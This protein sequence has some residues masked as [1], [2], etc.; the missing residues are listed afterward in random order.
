MI[1]LQVINRILT[2]K[3]LGYFIQ[4]GVT[5]DYFKAYK[6]EFNFILDHYKKYGNIPDKET[7]GNKFQ[8]FNFLDVTESEE[9]LIDNLLET[10]L[11]GEMVPFVHG[12]AEKLKNDSTA[13]IQFARTE[14]ERL[15]KIGFFREGYDIINKAPERL[16][17]YERRKEAKG[18]LGITTGLDDLDE[19]T[20]GWLQED[21]ISIVGRTNEGKTW[22][23]LFFLVAAWK[24]G[25]KILLYSG[26]MGK[27]MI[28][29]RIDTILGNFSNLGLIAGDEILGEENPYLDIPKR[30]S[31][32]YVKFVDGLNVEDNPFI[33]ITPSD[34]GGKKLDVV[35]LHSL[36]EKYNPDIVGIDQISLMEDIRK[37]ENKRIKYANISE[38]LYLTSERYK[39]PVLVPVQAN[40]EIM[41]EKKKDITPGIEHIGEADA[42]G[43][44][45]TRIISIRQVDGTLKIELRKNRYGLNNQE[46][47]CIWDIDR[48]ILKPA[49]KISAEI[50]EDSK[51]ERKGEDEF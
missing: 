35:T 40:R 31:D 46:L 22:L 43:Q 30:D 45:S 18:L 34:L 3:S 50:E 29:F 14:M 11:Y 19:F 24:T 33:V 25:K 27:V 49:L 15:Q 21:L 5:E 39:I 4:K 26:E 9:Y 51:E 37:G 13:A 32:D 41:K 7:F 6:E 44:N 42:I 48:G 36:I 16:A 23:L 1:E 28:G 2:E 17:E 12:I 47:I 38:D 10:Y 8:E 20:N